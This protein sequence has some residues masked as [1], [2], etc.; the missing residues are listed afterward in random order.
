MPKW[1]VQ[2]EQSESNALTDAELKQWAD[3]GRIAPT[4]VLRLKGKAG[5][6]TAAEVNGLFPQFQVD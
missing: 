1:F 2:Q 4:T 3:E 5:T 6:F